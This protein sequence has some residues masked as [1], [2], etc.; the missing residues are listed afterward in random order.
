MSIVRFA[1]GDFYIYATDGGRFEMFYRWHGKKGF[2]GQFA[3]RAELRAKVE[4]LLAEP[5]SAPRPHLLRD[6]GPDGNPG[7]L[8]QLVG[9]LADGEWDAVLCSMHGP[10]MRESRSFVAGCKSCLISPLRGSPIS[11]LKPDR[12]AKAGRLGKP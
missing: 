4:E 7:R 5:D 12:E 6:H 11:P 1:D 2:T 8:R 9:L 10:R 3:D